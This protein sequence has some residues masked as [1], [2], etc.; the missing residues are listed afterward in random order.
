MKKTK[1]NSSLRY[2]EL[3]YSGFL[4]LLYIIGFNTAFSQL[5]RTNDSFQSYGLFINYN[6]VSNN[7]SFNKLPGVPNC[8]P[9][10]TKG[11]ASGYSFGAL[12]DYFSNG[13]GAE[14]RGGLNF[15]SGSFTSNE[16]ILLGING[17]P[18]EGELEHKLNYNLKN[19]NLEADFKYI[20]LDRIH[21]SIGLDSYFYFSSSYN[22]YE[23]I[24]KPEGKTTFLDAEGNDSHKFIRNEKSGE[25]PD[26]NKLQYYTNA[27]IGYEL[28]L[29]IDKS[30]LLIPEIGIEYGFSNM[31]K[32]ISWKVITAKFGVSILFTNAKYE[33]LPT[34]NKSDIALTKQL[35]TIKLKNDS[36]QVDNIRHLTEKKELE[37]K[38]LKEQEEKN[39]I[40]K[41][42]N[43]K[44]KIIS[45]NLAGI[46]LEK[47]RAEKEKQDLNNQI[48]S[49]NALAGKNC[50]C[51]VILY[52]SSSDKKEA[53]KILNSL[54]LK[55]IADVVLSQYTD[56]LLKQRFYRI[57]SKCYDSPSE[58]LN[59]KNTISPI[60]NQ[61]SIKPQIIC[62]K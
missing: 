11:T 15:N 46:A 48:D 4:L 47:E 12:F 59:Q 2:L 61:L 18:V 52:S 37:S 14:I 50:T 62:D 53:N 7:A 32:G 30:M 28:P 1:D 33:I 23:K 39:R 9:E 6:N 19:L 51:F 16:Y 17:Q 35:E 34:E 8:C 54:K 29:N 10:F 20:L 49:E 44:E 60:L 40:E 56:A 31:I 41:E 45:D 58:A 36:L 26:L 38:F 3:R 21:L 57:K 5:V 43:A 24:V 42:L 55:G 13:I 27:R 22:Q 25:I